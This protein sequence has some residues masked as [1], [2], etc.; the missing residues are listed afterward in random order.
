MNSI[1]SRC[2]HR[3]K[4]IYYRDRAVAKPILAQLL[5]VLDRTTTGKILGISRQQVMLDE[6]RA[7][8]KV[9]RQMKRAVL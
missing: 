6:Y 1:H 2:W 7:L 5:P 4:L 3:R 9:V 8:A